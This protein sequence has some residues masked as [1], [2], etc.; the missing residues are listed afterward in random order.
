MGHIELWFQDFMLSFVTDN[1]LHYE[2]QYEGTLTLAISSLHL[3]TE[4]EAIGNISQE[5][6]LE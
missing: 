4:S 1:R 2:E 3:S 5:C 6:L